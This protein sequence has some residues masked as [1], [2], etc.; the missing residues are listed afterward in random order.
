MELLLRNRA[1]VIY[2]KF[3]RAPCRKNLYALDRKIIVTF[4]NGL[5]VLYHHAKFGEDGAT[6]SGCRCKN[7]VFVCLFFFVTLWVHCSVRSRGIYLNRHCVR[8]YRSIFILF[9]QFFPKGLPL[10]D[11]LEFPFLSPGGATIF[12]NRGRKFRKLQT[13]IKKFERPLRIHCVQEKSNPLYT[14]S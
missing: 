4:L 1:S 10:S 8:V 14:L 12:T 9:S 5:D 2:P 11:S 3:I 7:V 6:H 13:L